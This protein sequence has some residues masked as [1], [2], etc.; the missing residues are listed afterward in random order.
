VT[1]VVRAG[2]REDGP[3][4]GA[5]DRAVWSP[6]HSVGPRPPADHDLVAAGVRPQ[7]VL[8]AEDD[9]EVAGYV[10]L[11]RPTPLRSNRHVLAITGLAVDPARRRA[12]VGRL[13]VEAA[14]VEAVARGATRLTLRVLAPNAGARALYAAC[15]FV[16]EGV[17]AGEFVLDGA[18][19]DD[20]LMA[21]DLRG[22]GRP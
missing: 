8:V 5:L 22:R 4:L 20:V 9:G 17:L 21:R 12:G 1:P 19:V 16:V 3:A 10:Q 2:R 13:L 14:A 7:D 15:G 6:R 11:G 18:P